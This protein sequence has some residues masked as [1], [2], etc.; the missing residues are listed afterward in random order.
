MKNFLILSL[1]S[2]FCLLACQSETKTTETPQTKSE[3]VER[4]VIVP[5]FDE[6]AAY[7]LIEK[8]LSFGP[9]VPNTKGHIACGDF[10][11]SEFKKYGCEITVQTFEK[12][13]FNGKMLKLRNIIASINP[14]AVKRVIIASHWDSRPFADQDSTNQNKP[15]LAANDGASGVGIALAMAKTIYEAKNKPDIGVDFIMFDGEDY[16]QPDNS[17]FPEVENSWCLGSQYWSENKHKP[18]YSA[19]YGV[20]LDMCGNKGAKFAMDGTSR[21]YAKGIVDKVWSTGN[22]LG[23]GNYFIYQESDPIIDDHFYVNTVAKIPM[24]DIID[25]DNSDGTY[26]GHYWHTHKDNM[27]VIST[28]TLKAVGQTLL[29]L[30]YRE[31]K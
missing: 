8:Q 19:Y 31:E 4:Q 25:Y 15:I 20:L 14:K 10:L 12:A 28:E 17:G 24:A 26:F 21:N 2:A 7:S 3:V 27:D 29:D 1:V 22:R 18:N 6:K 13:A 5:S 9:R 11:I 30:V 23:Y 16:G